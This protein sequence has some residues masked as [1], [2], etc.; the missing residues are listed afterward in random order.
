M[1][2]R[3]TASVE[4]ME[5]MNTIWVFEAEEIEDENIDSNGFF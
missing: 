1:F 3:M 2:L 4:K 5:D